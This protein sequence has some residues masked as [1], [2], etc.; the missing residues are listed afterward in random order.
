M[1]ATAAAAAPDAVADDQSDCPTRY[2][3]ALQTVRTGAFAAIK[4]ARSIAFKGDES[5]PDGLIFRASAT[6][7]GTAEAKALAE[8]ATIARDRGRATW[9]GSAN[10][11][12]IADRI[13]TDLGEYVSQ[14]VS[15]YLCGGVAEYLS[16]L[17]SYMDRIATSPSKAAGHH[18]VQT[19]ATADAIRAAV[20]AMRPVPAPRFAPTLRVTP[21]VFDLRQSKGLEREP[22]TVA[23]GPQF[24][25]ALPPL[26]MTATP[27]LALDS[28]DHRLAALEMLVGAA[29]SNGFLGEKDLIAAEPLAAGPHAPAEADP[30]TT[31]VIDASATPRPVLG[32]LT[33]LKPLVVGQSA[34]IRDSL[35]RRALADAFAHVEAL[36]HLA[37]RPRGGYDPMLAAIAAT[38]DAITAA[39]TAA[40]DCTNANVAAAQSSDAQSANR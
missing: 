9:I 14:D 31:S 26:A 23:Y 38:M 4:P 30:E 5:L 27:I 24:D 37:H 8:A 7:G 2:Q 39:H 6:R 28:D 11:R 29:R 20:M 34:P 16:T 18:A 15:P 17:Q 3:A 25:P 36:D 32:R 22:Q 1:L 19:D 35:V 10:D 13:V 40:C 12:W 21:L 33:A